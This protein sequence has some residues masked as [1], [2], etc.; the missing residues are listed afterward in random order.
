M[1]AVQRQTLLNLTEALFIALDDLP[2]EIM[3]D[4]DPTKVRAEFDTLRETIDRYLPPETPATRHLVDGGQG[5]RV[6]DALDEARTWANA[7]IERYRVTARRTGNWPDTVSKVAIW[8]LV[9]SA[10]PD[11]TMEYSLTK[12]QATS[13][14][15]DDPYL[16]PAPKDPS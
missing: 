4:R 13:V 11:E 1:N 7:Q 3:A 15:L 9:E 10:Q 8:S 5:V 12:G 2:S 6:F 14:V 16:P